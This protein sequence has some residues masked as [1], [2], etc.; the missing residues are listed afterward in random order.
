MTAVRKAAKELLHRTERIDLLINN[1]GVM[2]RTGA[3]TDDGSDPQLAVTHLGHFPHH[4][5][6]LASLR[7]RVIDTGRRAGVR[8]TDGH[9]PS[10][11]TGLFAHL[12]ERFIPK[13]LARVAASDRRALTENRVTGMFGSW[14]AH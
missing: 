3:F 5:H 2:W 8:A 4:L 12:T 11:V 7:A 6:R 14:L 9:Q 10:V 13:G 1:A